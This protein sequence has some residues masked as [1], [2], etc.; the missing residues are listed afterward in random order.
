MCLGGSYAVLS[1]PVHTGGMRILVVD[2]EPALRESVARSLRFEGYTV[3]T[4]VDSLRCS[5]TKEAAMMESAPGMAYEATSRSVPVRA[6]AA[7]RRGVG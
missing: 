7:H 6:A 2:D 5:S 1:R 3:A 4:A